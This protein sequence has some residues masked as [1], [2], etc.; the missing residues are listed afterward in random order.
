MRYQ[1]TVHALDVMDTVSVTALLHEW[2]DSGVLEVEPAAR[3]HATVR[4][5]GETDPREWTVDALHAL[6][7]TL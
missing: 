6:L 3:W 2:S 1:L 5:T 4:S 7:E